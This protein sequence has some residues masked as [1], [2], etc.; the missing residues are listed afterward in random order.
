MQTYFKQRDIDDKEMDYE[1]SHT[2][3]HLGMELFDDRHRRH[4]EHH[5]LANPL[6]K[7]NSKQQQRTAATKDNNDKVQQQQRTSATRDNSSGQVNSKSI[8]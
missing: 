4:T 6:T 3:Q 8:A 5:T 7:D 1:I 2:H